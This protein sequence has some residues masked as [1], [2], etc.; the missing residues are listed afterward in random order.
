[1]L[2]FCTQAVFAQNYRDESNIIDISTDSAT[3]TRP[4]NTNTEE[5]PDELDQSE[6]EESRQAYEEYKQKLYQLFGSQKSYIEQR[7]KD[8]KEDLKINETTFNETQN[9][10]EDITRQMEPLKEQIVTLKTQLDLLN[11]EIY[12][13]E[14]K[15]KHATRQIKKKE[16]EISLLIRNIAGEGLKL[17]DHREKLK[18]YARL[19]YQEENQFL[20]ISSGEQSLIKLFLSDESFGESFLKIAYF[21][22]ISTQ[23]QVIM[24]DYEL[25]KKNLV[26]KESL[27]EKHRQKIVALQYMLEKEQINMKLQS[28]SKKALLAATKGEEIRY[29]Q[30]LSEARKEQ[31]NVAKEIEGL[32]NN[33]AFFQ[34]KL[35]SNTKKQQQLEKVAEDTYDEGTFQ[36]VLNR[37]YD[38]FFEL[39]NEATLRWPVVP[40][41]GISAYFHDPS[42]PYASQIGE[43]N[44]IDIP[45][46]HGT[47]IH[48]PRAAVVGKL[49]KPEDPS[50]AYLILIHGDSVMTV[51]GHVSEILVE[52]GDLVQEGDIIA[53][54]G[55]QIGSNGAGWATTGAHLHFEVYKNG[56][57]ADPLEFL[58]LSELN[59]SFVPEKF[60]VAR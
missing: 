28:E 52:E 3:I 49:K 13:T 17:K 22:A 10:M 57:H 25:A 29:K 59:A 38:N 47:P 45:I 44:A 14:I 12:L 32:E 24:Y 34:E 33:V 40:S 4:D 31:L 55:G 21:E 42:Y 27:L 54:S 39:S 50:Y 15:T 23:I 8:L 20:N 41:R 1:M 56:K 48:A 11:G 7:I 43:H 35:K 2:V 19:M 5:I 18:R 26:D 30:L 16:D 9:E 51:Y 58:P 36:A 6:E 53:L 37:E 60:K 46:P